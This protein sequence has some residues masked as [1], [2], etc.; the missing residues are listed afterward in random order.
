[1][2]EFLKGMFRVYY[3]KLSTKFSLV[4]E[5]YDFDCDGLI[6]KEDVRVVLAYVPDT[7]PEGSPS[8]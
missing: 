3:S 6:S 2:N 8:S 1:M 7:E 4:F 5:M